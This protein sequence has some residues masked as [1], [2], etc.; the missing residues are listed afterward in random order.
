LSA[1]DGIIGRML[2][3]T[4]E[5]RRARLVRRHRIDGSAAS[6]L[7]AA[8]AMVVLHATDPASVYLSALARV[9][10]ATLDDV[11]DA[12]YVDGSLLRLLAMRRT[13]FVAPTDFAP[14]VHHAASTRFAAD[15][16]KTLLG[17]LLHRRGEESRA[18]ERDEHQRGPRLGRVEVRASRQARPTG[19]A[20]RCAAGG[21]THSGA[22]AHDASLGTHQDEHLG[23][24]VAAHVV[25][26][27]GGRQDRRAQPRVVLGKLVGGRF[28]APQQDAF[29]AKLDIAQHVVVH[30]PQ[31]RTPEP[32]HGSCR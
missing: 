11:S 24:D 12:L 8:R 20:P 6:V 29:G 7:D 23:G 2:T 3:I 30:G 26:L 17:Q 22:A 18:R 1:R 19:P 31:R 28:T 21:S 13:L 4:A 15:Q 10:A 25:G 5:Q 27:V 16:R 32:R 9:P 14:V